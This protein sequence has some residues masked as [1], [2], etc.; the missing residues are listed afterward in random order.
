MITSADGGVIVHLSPPWA[1]ERKL[2]INQGSRGRQRACDNI[3]PFSLPPQIY[4]HVNEINEA[5][6]NLY[7]RCGYED[8][9]NCPS[10]RVFTNKLGLS[11]G[12]YGQRHRLMRKIIAPVE[13]ERRASPPVE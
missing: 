10:S 11:G 1:T 6:V 5:A 2:L 9:P 13:D 7:T 3:V 12:F 8:A 4:L